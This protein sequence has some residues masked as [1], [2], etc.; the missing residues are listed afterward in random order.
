MFTAYRRRRR[1]RRAH[2]KYVKRTLWDLKYKIINL[3]LACERGDLSLVTFNRRILNTARL[4]R[5]YEH[6]LAVLNKL[7]G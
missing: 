7:V 6:K 1:R 4:V 3:A 2:K 5:R